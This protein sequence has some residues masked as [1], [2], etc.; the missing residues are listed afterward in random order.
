[1]AA[2]ESMNR[3]LDG[4]PTGYL[5]VLNMCFRKVRQYRNQAVLAATVYDERGY[6]GYSTNLCVKWLKLGKLLFK[7]AGFN[8]DDRDSIAHL[9][10]EFGEE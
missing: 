5:E 8:T 3:V 7:Q 4:D 10:R 1:M 9:R 2:V 6:A